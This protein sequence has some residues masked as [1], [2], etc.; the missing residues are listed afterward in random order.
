[1]LLMPI[2]NLEVIFENL[3]WKVCYVDLMMSY[4]LGQ[5]CFDYLLLLIILNKK[6]K[7]TEKAL[8]C[9]SLV[10]NGWLQQNIALV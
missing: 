1:M 4:I 10:L 9:I 3:M 2:E 5:H 6:K 8:I 7:K